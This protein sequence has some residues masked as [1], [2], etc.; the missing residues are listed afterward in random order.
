MRAK[1]LDGTILD[2]EEGTPRHVIERVALEQTDRIRQGQARKEL[3]AGTTP[4]DAG[5]GRGTIPATAPP[6]PAPQPASLGD[7]MGLGAAPDVAAA[8]PAPVA[9][10]A[11]AAGGF[12][13]QPPETPYVRPARRGTL[14]AVAPYSAQEGGLPGPQPDIRPPQA[15]SDNERLV[16]GGQLARDLA[17]GVEQTKGLAA[18]AGAFVGAARWQEASNTLKGMDDIDVGKR[19]P[20]DAVMGG[21]SPLMAAYARATPEE[22]AN[23]RG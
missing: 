14:A 16:S 11:P 19:P 10:A 7:P 18:S 12:I 3:P 15:G 4:S 20:S 23:L 6:E 5:A 8:P 9:P 17:G 22:R 13:D 21:V 2:F 1:L